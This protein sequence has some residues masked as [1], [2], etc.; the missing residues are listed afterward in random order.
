[1]D[2]LT[3]LPEVG[4]RESQKLDFKRTLERQNADEILP[5]ICAMANALGGQILIGAEEKHEA[6][7]G[8][9]PLSRA[10]ASS[11]EQ[12]ILSAARDS[13]TP[14]PQ[15]STLAIE[16]DKDHYILV[17]NVPQ[18]LHKPCAVRKNKSTTFYYRNGPR[19]EQMTFEHIRYTF[20][21]QVS[22]RESVREWIAERLSTMYNNETELCPKVPTA[23]IQYELI[24]DVAFLREDDTFINA[25]ELCQTFKRCQ[26][27]SHEIV[28]VN[29]DGAYLKL[30]SSNGSEI[31]IQC[32]RNGVIEILQCVSDD[33]ITADDKRLFES[34]CYPFDE[35]LFT[36][37]LSA[38]SS[39]SDTFYY[40]SAFLYN[41]LGHRLYA[42]PHSIRT[43]SCLRGEYDLVRRRYKKSA[44]GFIFDVYAELKTNVRERLFAI[45]GIYTPP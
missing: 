21:S 1:M 34:W 15:V 16:Y 27:A 32:F 26:V 24:P 10:D 30:H 35:E 2:F 33:D 9:H 36:M 11:F 13:I 12:K 5:D 23:Q 43:N 25:Y 20:Q 28:K 3:Q 4:E 44:D 40:T 45:F 18:S 19:S 29:S 8:F 7:K 42:T 39:A 14:P 31:G 6:L 22:F 38:V 37:C 17:V 41:V